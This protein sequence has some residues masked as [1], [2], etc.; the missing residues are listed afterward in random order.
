MNRGGTFSTP[1]PPFYFTLSISGVPANLTP[2]EKTAFIDM[3]ESRAK[4]TR[5][6]DEAVVGALQ[7]KAPFILDGSPQCAH[8]SFV[9]ELFVNVIALF[10]VSELYVY[11]NVPYTY[12]SV[13]QFGPDYWA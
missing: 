9:E 3:P 12:A 6:V 2:E 5:A 4:I 10:R 7:D 13:S 1:N 8:S 11:C